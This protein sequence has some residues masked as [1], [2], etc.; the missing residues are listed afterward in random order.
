MKIRE[1]MSPNVR[2]TSPRQTSAEAAGMM[3]EC[4]SG[5]FPVG[6]NDRLV[7]MI[8]DRDIVMRAVAKNRGPITPIRDVIAS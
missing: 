2:V 6:E 5:V 4:D 1:C 8:T 3:S 7:G